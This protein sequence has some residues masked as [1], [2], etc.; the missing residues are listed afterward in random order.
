M[1][2]K[3]VGNEQYVWSVWRAK[4]KELEKSQKGL[5][6]SFAIFHKPWSK[7]WNKGMTRFRWTEGWK[8]RPTETDRSSE[9]SFFVVGNNSIK[10]EAGGEAEFLIS[11]LPI[12]FLSWS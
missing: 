5:D 9:A 11:L 7:E 6:Q 2:L 8:N 4:T 12:S 1:E 10:S 3:V